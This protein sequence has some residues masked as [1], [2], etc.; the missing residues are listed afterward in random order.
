MIEV[1]DKCPRCG[2][3]LKIQ[4]E[5]ELRGP[6]RE[7]YLGAEIDAL[8]CPTCGATLSLKAKL[9]VQVLADSWVSPGEIV[10]YEQE[11]AQIIAKRRS[12]TV[13]D[14]AQ[15]RSSD[16]AAQRQL[17]EEALIT[18]RQLDEEAYATARLQA[19]KIQQA[20][21]DDDQGVP[22]ISILI[23]DRAYPLNIMHI[24][25]SNIIYETLELL[26]KLPLDLE[27]DDYE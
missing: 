6:D 22:W 25:V 18:A 21:I 15:Y 17:L 9:H 16:A 10:S 5:P 7:L 14:L 11:Q 24:E 3:K 23:K 4:A 19:Q 8:H 12:D 27:E 1:E 2:T 13:I 26:T 20:L